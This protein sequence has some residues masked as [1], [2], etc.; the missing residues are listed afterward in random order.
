FGFLALMPFNY[1][2]LRYTLFLFLPMSAIC[3]FAINL[4]Y[5]KKSAL[6]LQN[7]LISLPV[8]FLLCLYVV[9]QVFMLFGQSAQRYLPGSQAVVFSAIMAGVVTFLIYIRFNKRKRSVSRILLA[10]VLV[11]LIA[12]VVIRQGWLL[13]EGLVLP[14]KYLKTLNREVSQLIDRE[15]VMTGPFAPA[16]SIDNNLKSFIYLF[17]L[18]DKEKELLEE[19][20][21][22]HVITDRSNWDVAIKDYPSLSSALLLRW[23]RLR[24]GVVELYRLPD[25]TVPTTDYER[26]AAAITERQSD[27]AVAYS[28]RFIRQYPDNLSG[29]FG[30]LITRYSKGDADELVQAL[31]GLV[32]EHPKDYRVHLFCRDFYRLLKRK[33]GDN[34]YEALAVHHLEQARRINPSL[35]K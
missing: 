26:A 3:A 8:T 17:G 16:F 27:S 1:R 23:M 19:Y 34:N 5:E 12:G 35:E 18:A 33:T 10:I 20:P 30:L 14:G 9:M 6:T 4:L 25:A 31:Q 21:I 24:D 32:A 2:P 15:S 22:T 11:P 7:K 28:E 29:Q 13:Y